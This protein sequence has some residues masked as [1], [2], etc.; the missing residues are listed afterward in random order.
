MTVVFWAFL[1]WENLSFTS[2]EFTDIKRDLPT[3][4]IASFFIMMV[5]YL[6]L[7]L[8]VIGILSPETLN[9][10]Q[11]P[12]AEV[13]N[14]T[15]G[16]NYGR[17]VAV[18]GTLIMIIN[19]NAWVWGPSRLLYDCGRKAVL[20]KTFGR[21]SIYQTPVLSLLVLLSLYFLILFYI[22]LD[23]SALNGLIKLA[24]ANFM[25]LYLLTIISFLKLAKK[26]SELLLGTLAL[27]FTVVMMFY[28]VYIYYSHYCYFH[29]EL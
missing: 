21:L 19:L 24:N 15:L 18:I 23:K 28:M 4:V 5:L 9:T 7:S 17:L 25:T 10:V 11:A 13:I 22:Y 14:K 8:S 1:G 29:L 2:E 27:C 12:L 16:N 26:R 3:S 20:P 6:G